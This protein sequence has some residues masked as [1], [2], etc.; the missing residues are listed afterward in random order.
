MAVQKREIRPALMQ[1][2]MDVV[3]LGAGCFLAIVEEPHHMRCVWHGGMPHGAVFRTGLVDVL[4]QAV[5]KK[6]VSGASICV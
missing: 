1:V 3:L 4:I 5:M 6:A 2:C